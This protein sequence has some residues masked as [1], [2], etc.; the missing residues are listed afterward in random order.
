MLACE[1]ITVAITQKGIGN[2]PVKAGLDPYSPVGSTNH[3][4]FNT[5][6]PDLWQ[7]D[8]RRQN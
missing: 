3:V 5:T 1:R 8:S 2:R 6:K 7:T 4:R